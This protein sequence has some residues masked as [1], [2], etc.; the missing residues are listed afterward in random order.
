MFP[1]WPPFL[2]RTS[3]VV[4]LSVS[5]LLET[6]C[7]HNKLSVKLANVPRL[8][9]RHI[10]LQLVKTLLTEC[11]ISVYATALLPAQAYI[12]TYVAHQYLSHAFFS[13]EGISRRTR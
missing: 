11:D 5:Q 13:A 8:Q 6:T 1:T 4:F 9:C 3:Q 2:T 7:I 12:G 10:T